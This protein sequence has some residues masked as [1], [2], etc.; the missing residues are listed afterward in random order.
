MFVQ[1]RIP[2]HQTGAFTPIVHDYLSRAE[3]L[4]PFYGGAADVE[5][6]AFAIQNRKKTKTNRAALVDALGNQYGGLDN[7]EKVMAAIRS[8]ENEH[9]F[10]VC[11][12][13][14]PN[15]FTGPLYFLYKI[16]HTIRLAEQL[17]SEFP[18]NRFVPIFYMGS[19]DADLAELNHF[20]VRGKR[21]QWNT[22][23]KGA[24]G[25]MIIDKEVTNLL[26]GLHQQLGIEPYGEEVCT[27]LKNCFREGRTIQEA[28]F[29]LVHS[30]FGRY[31]LVVLIAD[32]PRLKKLMLPV[33]E[34]DLFSTQ[35]SDLVSSTSNR[36][37]RHYNA[38]AYP[39]SINLFYL[40]DDMRERIEQS[41]EKF[42]VCHTSIT[43][44]ADELKKELEE[45][46]ERFSPNVILRGLY[47]EIILP[48]VAFIG[49][50]GE[51]A[52][53]LQLKDLFD[54]Y[55]VP[56]PVL[57]LRNSFLVIEKHQKALMQK[58]KLSTAEIFQPELDIM[59]L[60]LE[61]EGKK[62]GLNGEVTSLQQIYD[63][64]KKTAAGVDPTLEQHVE[65]LRTRTVQKLVALEKKML[66]A[67]RKKNEAVS[68]QVSKLKEQLFPKAGL[69][70]RVE[71]F[72][73]Y[74]ARWGF[75]F[76]DELYA[77]SKGLEQEFSILTE[78]ASEIPA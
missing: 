34:K 41:G 7:T 40:K 56:F 2:Y 17:S 1:E 47:Q 71:N 10:T 37:A 4:R 54:H 33:F 22:G 28:T 3:S 14:Q 73:T 5:G 39:R 70:E 12:A 26:S 62:P 31:G 35:H 36:L 20:T 60:C 27:L 46:P 75:R 19:E 59:N 18:G 69:Q 8:L 15:L 66:R 13:H 53:W 24:V 63:E 42:V 78:V 29:H 25:R 58:L 61:K 52:Y 49:G 57:V 38:Q 50:G 48:N 67:E 64:L 44:T 16:L 43:F 45:H 74:Y 23:Q 21:Y 77:A 76:I 11:T 51:L 32:H 68:R 65:A 72:T 6:I 55:A 9:T 30:L